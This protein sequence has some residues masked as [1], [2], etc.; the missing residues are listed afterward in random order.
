MAHVA[1]VVPPHPAP[2][3]AQNRSVTSSNG[4][5]AKGTGAQPLDA[6]LRRM[7]LIAG[8]C[9]PAEL[10]MQAH[11]HSTL[12]AAFPLQAVCFDVDSTLWVLY[13]PA[14]TMTS[15]RHQCCQLAAMALDPVLADL[16]SQPSALLHCLL[17]VASCRCL[18][19]CTATNTIFLQSILQL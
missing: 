4:N 12:P 17:L 14:C 16:C 19:A 18:T 7:V 8:S 5:M 9:F 15:H 13:L 11:G 6:L 10:C 2:R 3:R 1:E